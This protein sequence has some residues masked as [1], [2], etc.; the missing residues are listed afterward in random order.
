MSTQDT[1]DSLSNVL[2]NDERVL[3]AGERELLTNLLHRANGSEIN[4]GRPTREVIARAIG[5]TIAQRAYE[6]LGEGISRRLLDCSSAEFEKNL[7]HNPPLPPSPAPG[8]PGSG[9]RYADEARAE[10]QSLPPLPPSPAPGPPGSRHRYADENRAETQGMPPLPPSPAPGPPGSRR[11]AAGQ[12]NFSQT[13]VALLE[14]ASVIAA[15]CVVFDEF[16]APAEMQDL[17]EYTLHHEA[18]FEVSEVISPSD[19]GVVDFESRRSRVLMELGKHEEVLI[20]R[21]QACMPAVLERLGVP[22]F[23]ANNAEAQI[24]ASNDGDFFHWHN[25]NSH[26][27]SRSREIT[28]VYFFHREPRPF[29]GGEL[30]IYDSRM[31][32]GRYM[33][34]ENYRGIVPRQNQMVFFQSSLAHEITPVECPSKAFGDSRFTVNGWFHR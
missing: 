6:I 18:E 3:S 23:V 32:R 25:D 20:R 4:R 26:G 27:E 9:R 17:L 16:L 10:T 13:E 11:V 30:R 29:R 1:L 5:E 21:I 14:A 33:P 28:F 19:D 34:T 22:Q 7:K 24:T 31:E 8:P 2:L 12:S 15:Q